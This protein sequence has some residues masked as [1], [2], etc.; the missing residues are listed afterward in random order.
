MFNN[1]LHTVRW[2]VGSK[3]SVFSFALVGAVIHLGVR[4]IYA[5]VLLLRR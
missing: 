1:K 2:S 4:L 5:R 3:I